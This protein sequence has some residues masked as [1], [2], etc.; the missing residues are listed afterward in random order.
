MYTGKI[1]LIDHVE[2]IRLIYMLISCFVGITWHNPHDEVTHIY[3]SL[4]LFVCLF[5]CWFVCLFVCSFVCLFVRL[6]VR[7]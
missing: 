6:Y 2:A 3:I 5:V 4:C 1:S 7:F